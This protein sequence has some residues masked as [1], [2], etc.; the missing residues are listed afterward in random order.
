MTSQMTSRLRR[1]TLRERC[2]TVAELTALAASLLAC[3]PS[4]PSRPHTTLSA[5][6]E[7]LRA[8]FNGDTGKVRVVML[9]APT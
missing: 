2:Y 1:T 4:G 8:A 3:Q 9:V 7:A 5:R 6:A